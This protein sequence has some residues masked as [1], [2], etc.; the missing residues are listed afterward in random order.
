MSVDLIFRPPSAADLDPST[1]DVRVI[2]TPAQGRAQPLPQ[3]VVVEVAI[4]PVEVLLL[5]VAGGDRDALVA[6][7]ARMTGLVHLNVRRI[8]RDATRAETVTQSSFADLQAD[9]A[10]F[11]PDQGD[12][13]TWLLTRAHQRAVELLRSPQA[14]TAHAAACSPRPQPYRGHDT[15]Q[16]ASRSRSLPWRSPPTAPSSP[17]TKE[18]S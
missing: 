5:S 6:L 18:H 10:G 7:R 8:L 9:A 4:D 16:R 13:Q 14:P 3:L 12:A 15:G 11:D 1:G 2:D 17:T